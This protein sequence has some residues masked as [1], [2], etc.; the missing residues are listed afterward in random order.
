MIKHSLRTLRMG[1]FYEHDAL[2]GKNSKSLY[3]R[4]L[5][6]FSTSSRKISRSYLIPTHMNCFQ[7]NQSNNMKYLT[8]QYII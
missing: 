2:L 8:N 4:I 5:V 3:L 6:T 1:Q 7:I